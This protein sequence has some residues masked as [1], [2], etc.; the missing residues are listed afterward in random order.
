MKWIDILFGHGTELSSLQMGCRAFAA[1]FIALILL[2]I[3]GVRTFGK[4]SPFDNVIVIMLGSVLSRAVVGASP[5]IATS[6]ACLV[7]VVIHWILAKLSYRVEFIGTL[8]KGKKAVLYEESG[9]NKKNMENT[10][11]S[12]EDLMEEIRLQINQDD[13]KDIKK[14]F[15][16]RNGQ[17]SIIKK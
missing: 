10:N 17:I 1:F 6:V 7:L 9:Q 11:I 4:K 5:F 12:Q 3:A 14:I 16:E 13:L 8:V 15:I 2:R